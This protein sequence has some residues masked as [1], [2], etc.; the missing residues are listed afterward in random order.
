MQDNNFKPY[1]SPIKVTCEIFK[2]EAI[3]LEKLRKHAYGKFTV[4]KVDGKIIRLEINHSQLIQE[5]DEVSLD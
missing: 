5:D 2:T 3:L 4:Q 1:Q